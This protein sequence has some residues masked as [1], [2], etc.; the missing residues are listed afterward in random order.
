MASAMM[1]RK[2]IPVSGFCMCHIHRVDLVKQKDPLQ[3]GVTPWKRTRAP[4]VQLKPFEKSHITGLRG[5]R[6]I[7][8]ENYYACWM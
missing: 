7:I 1:R 4:F 5:A 2:Q 6:W 8:S 3:A